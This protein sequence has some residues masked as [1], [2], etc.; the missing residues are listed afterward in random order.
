MVP[1]SLLFSA[2]ASSGRDFSGGNGAIYPVPPGIPAPE[3]ADSPE[4]DIPEQDGGLPVSE[5]G[6]IWAYILQDRENALREGLPISDLGYFGAEVD[7]YGKLAAVPNPRAIPRFNGRVH[8][9]VK[10]DSYSLT[11]FVLKYN[12]PE[13]R[14]LIA[15]LLGAA[16][17]FDGLQIDFEYIPVRD[18]E[19]FFSFLGELRAGLRDKF[20][21][22]ALKA[23]TRPV[24]NDVHDYAR[25]G[26]LVDRILVMA[27]DEHWAGSAPGPVAGMEWCRDVAS[28]ACSVIGREKLIMGLPFY[29]RAWIEP[30]PAKAYI[31][32]QI[33]SLLGENGIRETPREK[34]I[35]SFEFETPVV[36][37]GY[38]ED[39]GSLAVRLRMYRDMG[40]R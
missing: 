9:V 16:R 4:F 19:Q 12:S 37:K 20:F 33:E 14:E 10:C 24:N 35:P 6:E 18:R 21:T 3:T 28:Y 40:V 13:R 7:S 11:H 38:Y 32:S 31:Y 2:C 8:L 27:Y 39:S 5:F 17:N 34:G 1:V 29:G 36:V 25:I 15:D 30:N 22:V 23:R 26:P